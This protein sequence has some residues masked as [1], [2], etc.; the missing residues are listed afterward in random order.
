MPFVLLAVWLFGCLPAAAS[1]PVVRN[2]SKSEYHGGTQNWD[3]A[4][5]GSG[6]MYFANRLGMLQTDGAFWHLRRLDNFGDARC[7]AIDTVSGRI[8]VGGS[9]TF[10][11]FAPFSPGDDNGFRSLVP[12]IV[13]GRRS[14]GDVWQIMPDSKGNWWFQSDHELYC[15]DG[16]K[17][18][19][20]P[21][22]SKIIASG[23][24]GGRL[25]VALEGGEICRLEGRRLQEI[26]QSSVLKGKLV[27]KLVAHPQIKDALLAVTAFDGCYSV[28]RD[29]VAPLET[30]IDALLRRGQVFTAAS[31]GS[32]VIFGTVNNGAVIHDF[33]DDSTLLVDKESGMQ[34]NT[35]LSAGFDMAGNVWL[36]LDNGI[37]MVVVNSPVRMLIPGKLSCGTGYTS[38]LWGNTLLLGTNQGLYSMPYSPADGQRLNGGI[39]SLHSE[40]SGQVWNISRARSSLF[41]SSDMGLYIGVPGSLRKISDFGGVWDAHPIDRDSSLVLVSTYSDYYLFEHNG[42]DWQKIGKVKGFGATHGRFT[43][44]PGGRIWIADWQH[45]MYSMRIDRQ[46]MQFVDVRH[47]DGRSGIADTRNNS[48]S[49]FRGLPLIS[50]SAGFYSVDPVTLKAGLYT[51][52]D[53]W[54]PAGAS[55]NLHN[56][57]DGSLWAVNPLRIVRIFGPDGALQCDSVSYNGLRGNLVAGFD[58]FNFVGDKVIVSNEDGFYEISPTRASAHVALPSLK[59]ERVSING[60]S[61]VYER[62][63]NGSEEMQPLPYLTPSVRFMASYPEY[64]LDKAVEYSFKLEGYDKEWSPY[65]TNAVKEYSRLSHGRYNLLVKARNNYDG[66]LAESSFAFTVLTPW[67]L[68]APMKVIYTMIV[69]AAVALLMHMLSRYAKQSARR[70]E[71]RK[72]EE[73]QGVKQAA[74]QERMA[75]DSEIESLQSS[76]REQ[77]IHH[78]TESLANVTMNAVHKNEILLKISER[79]EAMRA[80]IPLDSPQ[81]A[82]L[83]RRVDAV[84]SM[85]HQTIQKDKEQIAGGSNYEEV[86]AEYLET[87]L[88]NHPDLTKSEVRLC[89]FI[90]MGLSTKEIANLLNILPKTVEMSRYRLRKKLGL[91]RADNLSQYLQELAPTV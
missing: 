54:L 53:R 79:L 83:S 41:V 35:V 43:V 23:F 19:G 80:D 60:D 81:N 75:K 30:S 64:R 66:S 48:V 28:K 17:V 21:V 87:L 32:K 40:L 62:P 56:S 51:A 10:G 6:N 45:G 49:F 33:S 57:P 61:V 24:A 27:R 9:G 91:E 26:R 29:D 67:Y 18:I 76:R 72:N 1:Y 77:E 37:D 85:I 8:Y 78:R 82:R 50:S 63:A 46:K 90:K 89:C 20:I 68:S 22:E 55:Y 47:F 14:V 11:Y 25:Y 34:N 42:S 58:N 5:D 16:R 70:I 71:A 3:V 84:Q 52:F 2:F 4:Q 38:L 73:L 74:L 88:S 69:L 59:I 12:A 7:L 13:G 15:Y 86:Y 36:G 44:G 39:P 31:L 65:S